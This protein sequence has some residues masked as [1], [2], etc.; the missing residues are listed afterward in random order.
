MEIQYYTVPIVSEGRTFDI[1]VDTS[2]QTPYKM[3]EDL[4][5]IQ[6]EAAM[7]VS[8]GAFFRERAREL[9][10]LSTLK[11]WQKLANEYG[12]TGVDDKCEQF[13]AAICNPRVDNTELEQRMQL[14]VETLK[15]VI[16]GVGRQLLTPSAG[17]SEK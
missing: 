15:N 16:Q 6:Q 1:V 14:Q 11:E 3:P 5:E 10:M 12:I 17:P 4:T 9:S 2:H 8:R 7:Q 13:K